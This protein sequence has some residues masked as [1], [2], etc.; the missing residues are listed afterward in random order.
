[1]QG[2]G[3]KDYE[4]QHT[5]LLLYFLNLAFGQGAV[6]EANSNRTFAHRGR[7]ALHVAGAN[8]TDG[9]DARQ[10][11]FQHARA[12]TGHGLPRLR[13]RGHLLPRQNETFVIEG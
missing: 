9:E 13:S 8:V 11:S 12:R 5:V 3:R 2:R 1:M 10:A 7:D 4:W 6:D